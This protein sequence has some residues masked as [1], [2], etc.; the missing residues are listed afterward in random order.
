LLSFSWILKAQQLYA[1]THVSFIHPICTLNMT[2]DDTSPAPTQPP[3]LFQLGLD[4][5]I[6]EGGSLVGKGGPAGGHLLTTQ[7]IPPLHALAQGVGGSYAGRQVDPWW[8]T[9]AAA[10]GCLLQLSVELH[11]AVIAKI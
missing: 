5:L 9:S 7:L 1:T 10:A 8:R 6:V 4:L 2:H 11:D 3:T